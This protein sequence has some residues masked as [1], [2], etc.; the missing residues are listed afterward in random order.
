MKKL[1]TNQ[2]YLSAHYTDTLPCQCYQC[3]NTFYPTK[4]SITQEIRQNRNRIKY[5]STICNSV[6]QT[7]NKSTKIKLYCKY[8][9][10]EI[11]KT[12]LMIN[13]SINHFCSQS[14]SG[15][16]NNKHKTHGTRRSKLEVYL[17]DQLTQKFAD[18]E[19]HFNR[20]D[21]IGSELDIYVP[22]LNLAIELNGIFHY[23]PI[24]G[25]NKLNQI[26]ANDFSKSKACFDKEIDLCVIDTSQ[27]KRFTES[28]SQVFL[29]IITDIINQR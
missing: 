5:C 18:L 28:S 13:K 10:K 19:I 20:K 8:C 12:P 25:S 9:N 21:T 2:E 17:E 29:N 16:Y 1:F 24:F 7:I 6:A 22:S 4:H 3:S 26:Q 15:T 11:Y 23:E 27:Q 14:C